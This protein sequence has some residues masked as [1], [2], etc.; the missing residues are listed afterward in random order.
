MGS[1][2][3]PLLP[4]SILPTVGSP[5]IY[6]YLGKVKRNGRK[7]RGNLVGGIIGGE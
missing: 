3:V 5:L 2:W 1:P 6:G 4:P 7:F